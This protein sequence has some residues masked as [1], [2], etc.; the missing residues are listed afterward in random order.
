VC[1]ELMGVGD[2]LRER[3]RENDGIVGGRGGVLIYA[4][5]HNSDESSHI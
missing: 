3:D 4:I 5:E 2:G 1:V